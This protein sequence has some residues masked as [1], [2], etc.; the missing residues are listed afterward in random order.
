M[1]LWRH[2]N[3]VG[4]SKTVVWEGSNWMHAESPT[5]APQVFGGEAWAGRGGVCGFFRLRLFG[6]LVVHCVAQKTRR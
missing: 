5:S 6:G 4:I 2:Y 1:P 3:Y